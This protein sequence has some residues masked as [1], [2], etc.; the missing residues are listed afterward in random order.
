MRFLWPFAL[1][2]LLAFPPL[3]WAYLRV[4]RQRREQLGQYGRLSWLQPAIQNL[5]RRRYIPAIFFLT[6]LLT[7]VVALARPHAAISLPRVEG[8]VILAFDV[9]GSM[10]ADDWAPT[11]M[12]VAKTVAKAFVARQP[13]G[14]QV[15]VVAFSDGGLLVQNPTNDQAALNAAIDRLSPQ[16]GTSLGQ[17]IMASLNTLA[18]DSDQ[19]RLRYS[20]RDTPPNTAAPPSIRTP[21]TIVLL[22]DGENNAPP[23]P[24]DVAL[25]AAERG[26]RISTIGVGSPEGAVLQLEGFSVS[27]QLNEVLLQQVAG[28]T[29]GAYY[30]AQTP[31]QLSSIYDT[32][33]LQFVIKPEELEV[34]AL[35]AAAGIIFLL[36]GGITS[37]LWL[38]RMP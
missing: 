27:T 15:G 9:S 7:L 24:L 29:G 19:P 38:S 13:P 22:S 25:L 37:L 12:E 21:G 28:L 4:Q 11:R 6:G 23:E 33:D 20:T 8:T 16:R 30:N 3:I 17:G 26:V 18:A 32:I 1:V 5:G 34:T 14:V 2:L 35:F 31:E 36:I 10:A